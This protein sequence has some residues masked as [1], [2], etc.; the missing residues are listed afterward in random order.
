MSLPSMLVCIF[1][2]RSESVRDLR[3]ALPFSKTYSNWGNLVQIILRLKTR[4]ERCKAGLQRNMCI[5][6]RTWKQGFREKKLI[7]NGVKLWKLLT[8]TVFTAS[9]FLLVIYYVTQFVIRELKQWRF[10]ATHVNRKWPFFIFW[11]WF[12]ANFQSNRLYNS[13]EA[14]EYKFYIRGMFI[15]GK[16]PH[17]RLTCVAPKRRCLSSLL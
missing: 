17:F 5:T 14:K 13:K 11:R 12:R 15:R 4:D 6:A 2:K 16:I 1:S 9:P 7:N 10:W 8:P 3:C